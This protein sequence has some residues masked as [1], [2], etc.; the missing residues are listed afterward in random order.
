MKIAKN[1][2]LIHLAKKLLKSNNNQDFTITDDLEVLKLISQ[3]NIEVPYLFYNYEED[4]RPITK[5][6]LEKLIQQ[7]G[8]CFEISTSTCQMLKTKDN[9]AGIIAILKMP[10]A[11]IDELG[12]FIIVLDHLEIPGNIG[13]I[14]RTADACKVSGFILVDSISKISNP[15]ITASARGTNLIIPSVDLDYASTIDYLLKNDYDIFLGE[16]VLGKDYQS[17]DY[18]K[19]IAIVVGNERFGIN[20]DW[21]NNNHKK[22]YI[23][24]AGNNNSLNV[25]VAASILIYEA[26]MRRKVF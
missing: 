19:K 25:S 12:D 10:K 3:Y 15:K 8:E 11:C 21:Y 22:V 1:H 5:E 20:P 7:A 18:Q 9:H 26:A 24:M 13:T 6:L 16:P 23:P 4:F 2:E 14:Y 17:Y